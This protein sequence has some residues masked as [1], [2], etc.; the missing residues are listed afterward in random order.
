MLLK[1]AVKENLTIFHL[2]FGFWDTAVNM[3]DIEDEPRL[4]F[5]I[6]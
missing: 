2:E 1:G 4:P 6:N 5:R 3:T